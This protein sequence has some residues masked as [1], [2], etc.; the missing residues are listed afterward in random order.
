MKLRNYCVVIM[1]DTK[2]VLI[3]IEKVSDD[4][5]NVLDAKGI[6]IATFTSAL[7]INELNEWFKLNN[8]SY[9]VFDLSISGF[10]I[11]K[12]EVHDGLFSFMKPNKSDLIDKNIQD[13]I[14]AIKSKDKGYEMSEPI[15]IKTVVRERKLTEADIEDMTQDE[16]HK[17][18]NKLIDKGV[19]K[20]TDYDKELL[21]FLAK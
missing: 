3:E 15:D 2:N 17:M 7:R 16:K 5:P 12:K 1:G 11:T 4:K 8:R 19:E 14:D 20:L 21:Q 13:L 10:N 18:M 6:V 9:F